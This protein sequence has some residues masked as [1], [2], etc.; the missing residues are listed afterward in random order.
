M[1]LARKPSPGSRC[2]RRG[3]ALLELA[4][5]APILLY[6]LVAVADFGRYYVEASR[7]GEVAMAAARRAAAGQ[8]TDGF[9]GEPPAAE[10][11]SVRIETFCACPSEDGERF[12]CGARSCGSYGEPGRY[13]QASVERPFSFMARYPGFPSTFAIRRKAGVRTR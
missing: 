8:H 13:V 11:L 7:V 2:K 1:M 10:A 5:F 12:E 3:G 6:L 9:G 4:L